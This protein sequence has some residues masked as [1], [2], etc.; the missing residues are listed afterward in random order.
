MAIAP[1]RKGNSG[2]NGL[3]VTDLSVALAMRAEHK[4]HRALFKAKLGC[5]SRNYIEHTGRQ[6]IAIAEK[7]RAAGSPFK[8]QSLSEAVRWVIIYTSTSGLY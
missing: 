2:G 6:R 3:C 1:C 4:A 8:D 7:L 5:Y